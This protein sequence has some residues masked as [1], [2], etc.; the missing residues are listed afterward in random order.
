MRTEEMILSISKTPEWLTDAILEVLQRERDLIQRFGR[1][2]LILALLNG[3]AEMELRPCQWQPS[4]WGRSFGDGGCGSGG[5]GKVKVI[6][7]SSGGSFYEE[8]RECENCRGAGQVRRL[9]FRYPA[10]D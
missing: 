10:Y 4:S 2:E 5:S 6:C 9:K 7:E 3:E 8:I 1:R